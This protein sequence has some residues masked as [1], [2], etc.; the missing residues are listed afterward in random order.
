MASA[1]YH[2]ITHCAG[3]EMRLFLF[4][5]GAIHPGVLTADAV[6][7][8]MMKFIQNE[9]PTLSAMSRKEQLMVA[10]KLLG[11]LDQEA[12]IGFSR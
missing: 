6:N 11:L 8:P 12:A 7:S 10:R 5:Y 2:E 9:F 4:W 3:P 1:Y